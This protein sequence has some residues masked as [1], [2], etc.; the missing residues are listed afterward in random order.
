MVKALVYLGFLERLLKETA[1]GVGM[2]IG[3]SLPVVI[4]SVGLAFDVNRG[5]E[6]RVIN[7]R[8]AD[9]AALGAA[10]AFKTANDEAVLQPT[11]IDLARANGLS[12]ATVNAIVLNDLPSAGD[13]S[14]QVTVTAQV[15]YT[16]ARVVGMSGNYGVTAT[17]VASLSTQAQYA[18]PCFLALSNGSEALTTQG[19]ASINAP[20]CSVAA[21]GSI[22]NGGHSIT[23]HDI[24]SGSGNISTGWG[25]LVAET[26]RFAGSF[27][28]P[29]WNTSVP[30]ADKR[31]KQPTALVD[32]WASDAML[33]DARTQL[34]QFTA[35]PTLSD[36]NT[37]CSGGENWSLDSSPNN[38]NPAKAYWTESG[39]DIPAGTYCIKKL[40]V[41]GGVTVKFADG[42][43]ISVSNGF[44][45]GGNSV[46]FG[47]S[48]LRVNGGFDS[49]SSGVTIGDGVLWIGQGNIK[50]QGTNYK[51]DGDVIINDN[52]S[53]GGGQKF[54]M[55]AGQHHFGALKLGG[56][57][58]VVMGD[59]DLVAQDGIDVGGDSEV[60]MGNGDIV[61]GPDNSGTAIKLSGSGRL[62][63]GDGQFSANGDIDTNGGSRLVFGRTNNHYINGDMKISGAVLFGAGR[64][65]V[66]GDF[67]NGTGGTTW[68]Y[69]SPVTG[70]T[71]G[72]TLAGESVSGFDMV[73][74][75]VT[76]VL[77]GSFDLA[78]GARTKF[79]A[80]D[81]TTS[82][83]AI[84]NLLVDSLTTKN[85]DWT[86]G[87][88]NV[89]DGTV[90]FPNA[91]V[92]MAGG[93]STSG[94][95]ACFTLI[96]GYIKLAGG[97]LAGSACPEM[98]GA[99]SGSSSTIRLI[100]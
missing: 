42:S 56:G 29:D 22:D 85:I 73:G 10:I 77:A 86:G 27:S 95:G 23:T 57:G 45:N 36:P 47:N 35:P 1:G 3:L 19:G 28:A 70:N 93:N 16:L 30:P 97:A 34:G 7:Q 37:A 76:F 41:E 38:S 62:F 100:R 89:F 81:T 6:Q 72:P 25:S 32:P 64:Y 33:I 17:S 4:G 63:M 8:A 51:G 92:K 61:I 11:A 53:L 87:S 98:S 67:W 90:H 21:I 2:L 79:V 15:P 59:G 54:V 43:D 99:A 80:S 69:T 44:S 68:P 60:S 26:L 48:D 84:A 5:L 49:G 91:D 94:S 50:F 39:Y 78:G 12:G 83:G 75:D 52:V 55:G 82:D 71:Y 20:N 40:T 46:N 18:P 58:S 96:A 65:T 88:T 24:I 9:M 74:V 66:N 14:V 31:I 13:K